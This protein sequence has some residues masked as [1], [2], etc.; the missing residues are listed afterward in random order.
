MNPAKNNLMKKQLLTM[1][2]LLLTSFL[3]SAQL[4]GNPTVTYTIDEINTDGFKITFSPNEDCAGY[5][6]CQ[7]DAG[8]AEQQFAMFGTWMGFSTLGDMVKAWGFNA[9]AEQQMSWTGDT[10]GKDY[11]VYVQC[12]DVN[13]AYADMIIIPITT[14]KMGGEGLAEIEIEIGEFGGD[15]ENGYYQWVTYTPNDQVNIFHDMIIEKSAYDTDEWGESGVTNYLKQDMPMTYGWD[16]IGVDNAQWSATPDTEY[17]ACALGKN[18]N[19]EWGPL[20]LVEFKTPG[21]SGISD[22]TTSKPVFSIGASEVRALGMKAG[23]EVSLYDMSGHLVGK[24][25][26]NNRGEASL[27]TSQLTPGVYIVTNGKTSHKFVK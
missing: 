10:P 24:A 3:M 20:A 8:T 25:T 15:E 1:S 6:A 2:A 16:R 26:V 11:E 4:V 22:L 5:A 7:F 21:L 14:A 23:S 13:G 18:A 17:M 19:D 9:T 12:W 27:S